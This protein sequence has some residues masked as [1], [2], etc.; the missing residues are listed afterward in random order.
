MSI[1]PDVMPA[2]VGQ[3]RRK[4]RAEYNYRIPIR[5]LDKVHRDTFVRAIDNVLSTELA[6]FT[7]TQIIEGLPTA[8]VAWDRRLPGLYGDHPLDGHEELCPGAMEKARELCPLWDPDMLLFNPKVGYRQTFR[9]VS[10][11]G[12]APD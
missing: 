2:I 5:K 7:Y 9:S 6:I 10:R 4:A 3:L 12:V 8:D 1:W 11:G